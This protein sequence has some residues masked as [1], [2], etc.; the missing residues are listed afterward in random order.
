MN[1]D[2]DNKGFYTFRG[3]KYISASTVAGLL[4]YEPGDDEATDRLN[5][6]YA[7]KSAMESA[8]ALR[9]WKAGEMEWSDAERTILWVHDRKKAGANHRDHSA[10]CGTVEHYAISKWLSDYREI[11]RDALLDKMTTPKDAGG[12]GVATSMAE[13]LGKLRASQ[14]YMD[15]YCRWRDVWCPVALY[16]EVVV[17]HDIFQYMGRADYIGTCGGMTFVQD[18]KRGRERPS[19][20]L[21]T[22]GYA[23]A[24][25]LVDL[26]TGEVWLMPVIHRKSV[27]YLQPDGSCAIWKH[28]PLEP[29]RFTVFCALAGIGMS[30]LQCKSARATVLRDERGPVMSKAAAKRAGITLREV[31]PIEGFDNYVAPGE[32]VLEAA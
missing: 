3:Q 14:P 24:R 7:L 2:R 18:Y 4:N 6:W 29:W 26:E 10:A 12:L 17:L 11:G 25:Y 22:E 23:N 27:L 5:E 15:S 19:H 30:L 20:K 1:A 13:A 31:G 16:R 8:D 28:W 9:A 21:Q 32:G